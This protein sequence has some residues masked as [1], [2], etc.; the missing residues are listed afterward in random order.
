[1]VAGAVRG[2]G[3]GC[4]PSVGVSDEPSAFSPGFSGVASTP[5]SLRC[6]GVMGAGAAVSGYYLWQPAAHYFGLGR[7]GRDQLEDYAHR[8][9]V[10][11]ETA[12]R[13]LSANLAHASTG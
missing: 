8:R 11:V 6:S 9:G 13:W 7:I 10:S 5:A 4:Q 3:T 12:E 2:L 1:M